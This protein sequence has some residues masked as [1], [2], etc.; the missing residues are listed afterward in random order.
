M[1]LQ[2]IL[3]QKSDETLLYRFFKAQLENPTKNYW[4]SN[5]VGYLVIT[6]IQLELNE[7][8]DMSEEKYKHLCKEKVSTLAFQYLIGKQ[9]NRNKQTN[10]NND[11]LE[12]SKYLQEKILGF[13]T[14]KRKPI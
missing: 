2:H 3:K 14:R 4:V 1:Y 8:A 6:S 12:M 5:A 13:S 7:I 9:K 10:I 11:C